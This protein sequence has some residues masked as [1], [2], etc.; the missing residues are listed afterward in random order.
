MV[1]EIQG[2]ATFE[3][4]AGDGPGLVRLYNRV[5]NVPVPEGIQF[6]PNGSMTSW[7]L[8]L[9]PRLRPA[10]DDRGETTAG[11]SSPLTMAPNGCSLACAVQGLLQARPRWRGAPLA[12]PARCATPRGVKAG[13]DTAVGQHP[14][15]R[16]LAFSDKQPAW[17]S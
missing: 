6:E 13:R 2:D 5:L 3:E 17:P 16:V 7:P 14:T 4:V 8:G 11:T 9:F 1:F 15:G 10:P 12:L